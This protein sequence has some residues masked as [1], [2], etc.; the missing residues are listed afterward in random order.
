M[1]VYIYIA[2]LKLSNFEFIIFQ[3][4][5]IISSAKKSILRYQKMS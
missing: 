4:A 2:I 3:I 1:Y 5:A